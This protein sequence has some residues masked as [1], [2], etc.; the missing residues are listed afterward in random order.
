MIFLCIYSESGIDTDTHTIHENL[1][2]YVLPL[3]W[4][5]SQLAFCVVVSLSAAELKCRAI[6]TRRRWKYITFKVESCQIT[7]NQRPTHTVSG[8]AQ[9]SF[10]CFEANVWF[11][12]IYGIVFAGKFSAIVAIE[13]RT[14]VQ[15]KRGEDENEI[16]SCYGLCTKFDFSRCT[17]CVHLPIYIYY[18]IKS[19]TLSYKRTLFHLS[20]LC[21]F[22]RLKPILSKDRIECDICRC[23][24]DRERER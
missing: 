17:M 14:K 23:V 24:C 6:E 8:S 18:A 13:W 21:S 22:G 3:R 16:D 15:M 1:V 20:C 12:G 5:K 11:R 9:F 19:N 7:I 4:H 2:K 10:S